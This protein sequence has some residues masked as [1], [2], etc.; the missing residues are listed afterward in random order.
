MKH[1]HTA[2]AALIALTSAAAF[3]TPCDQVQAAIDAKIKANGVTNYT[4]EAIPVAE[5]KDQKVVGTC[6]VGA[7]KI[8]YT[9]TSVT[10]KPTLTV[11]AS[12][13]APAPA[14]DVARK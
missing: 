6:E 9:R 14:S 1:I 11:D 10:A 12:P 4:L 13:A 3:A 2:F 8:V 5:V 7:K